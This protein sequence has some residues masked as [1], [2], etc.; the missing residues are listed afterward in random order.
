[1]GC[2]ASA[3]FLSPGDKPA[4]QR[5]LRAW[6]RL[7][8]VTMRYGDTQGMTEFHYVYT[9]KIRV[10]TPSLNRTFPWGSYLSTGSTLQTQWLS[11]TPTA[12][13]FRKLFF[14]SQCA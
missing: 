5:N 7:P 8:A 4:E 12:L 2:E 1:M 6:A 14:G 11:R 9:R 13:R 3:I 10:A